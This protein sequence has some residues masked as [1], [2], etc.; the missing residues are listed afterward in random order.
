MG[1]AR[2]AWNALVQ[3]RV[4]TTSSVLGQMKAVKVMG[5]PD[6]VTSLIQSLRVQEIESSKAF[7]MFF[8]W[9]TLIGK[10]QTLRSEMGSLLTM[11]L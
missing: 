1:P 6:R 3:K 10:P 2:V 9:I 8:V 5:L 11:T 4:S 7:R